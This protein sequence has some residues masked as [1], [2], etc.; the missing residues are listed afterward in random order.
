MLCDDSGNDNLDMPKFI[1]DKEWPS[2]EQISKEI[3]LIQNPEGPVQ[4]SHQ[5]IVKA[6]VG[7]KEKIYLQS[8][9]AK[10]KSELWL[11]MLMQ[12]QLKLALAKFW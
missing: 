6:K 8:N 2:H 11:I 5:P 9:H 10:T 1:S 3:V 7:E 12:S 4:G